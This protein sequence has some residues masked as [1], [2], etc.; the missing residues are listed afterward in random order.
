MMVVVAILGT[1]QRR[2]EGEVKVTG[3]LRFTADLG[4]HGLA[5]ARLLLSTHPHARIKSIDKGAAEAVPGVIAVV[6]GAELPDFDVPGPDLPL[7]RDHVFF[8]GQP[9]AAVVA[10]SVGAAAD[11]TQLIEVEYEPLPAVTEPEAAMREDS[12]NVLDEKGA[13]LEDAGAHGRWTGGEAAGEE[14]PRNVQ[15]VSRFHR[16]DAHAALEEAEIVVARRYQLPAVHQG[17]IEPHISAA[18]QEPD[19]STTIWTSTQGA[20]LCR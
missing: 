16:G 17:F 7:A 3:A 10:D 15:A 4:I 14:K 8:V 9:V 18:R 13:A 11:A 5:H 6:T 20:Y 12:P 2:L 1:P 19:G